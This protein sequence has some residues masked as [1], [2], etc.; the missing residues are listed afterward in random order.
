[1]ITGSGSFFI[2]QRSRIVISSMASVGISVMERLPSTTTAPAMVPTAA[3]VTPSTKAM[4]PGLFPYL[5]KYGA[6]MMVNR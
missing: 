5:W 3:A 2:F 1:M 6:G 4:I